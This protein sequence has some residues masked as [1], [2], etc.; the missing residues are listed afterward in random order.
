MSSLV[1]LLQIPLPASARMRTRELAGSGGCG[2]CGS[3]KTCVWE[4]PALRAGSSNGQEGFTAK[5]VTE[6]ERKALGEG[7]WSMPRPLTKSVVFQDGLTGLL[8]DAGLISRVCHENNS[9]A[10]SPL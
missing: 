3:R 10:P 7:S 6:E 9:T 4:G 1:C 2:A 8:G 5:A